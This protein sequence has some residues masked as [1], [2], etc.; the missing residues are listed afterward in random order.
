MRRSAILA[1]AALLLLAATPAAAHPGH[2]GGFVAG[3]VHPFT[4]LDHMLAMVGVGLWAGLVCNRAWLAWPVTFVAFM[5]AGFTAG[6]VGG[7]LPMV[8]TVIA[9]SVIGLGLAVTFNVR[10]P[11]VVGAVAIAIAGLAHGYAHGQEAM[12]GAF[13][14][15]L[16]FTLATLA[17]HGMGLAVSWAI[18]RANARPLARVAG[19][20]VTAAGL[21]IAWA[22]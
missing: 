9:L 10:A 12:V 5:L 4:G 14:F 15:P 13:S 1:S 20:G 17:L 3:F 7:P 11:L 21:A 19:I 18:Q 6:V 16:G 2:G 22:G 8:E